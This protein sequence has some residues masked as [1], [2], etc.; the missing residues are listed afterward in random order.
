[1]YLRDYKYNFYWILSLLYS[2]VS[3]FIYIEVFKLIEDRGYNSELEGLHLI[4]TN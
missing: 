4:I 1:M 3:N 2:R